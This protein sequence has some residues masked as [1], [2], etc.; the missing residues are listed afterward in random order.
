MREITTPQGTS[1][2]YDLRD[3][4]TPP[5]GVPAL[6]SGLLACASTYVIAG[7]GGIG[8]T[9]LAL[10]LAAHVASGQP[11]LGH[12][13]HSPA[14]V[15]FA[16][17]QNGEARLLRRIWALRRSLA[18]RPELPVYAMCDTRLIAYGDGAPESLAHLAAIIDGIGARLVVI[19]SL[20]DTL[21]KAEENNNEDMALVI[22][23]FRRVAQITGATIVAIHHVAK[24]GNDWRGASAIRDQ[25]DGLITVSRVEEQ[26]G[27]LRFKTT[28]SRDYA[29]VE[30]QIRASFGE[31]EIVIERDG[32]VAASS[33]RD[34]LRDAILSACD[35]WTGIA[36][37]ADDLATTER[38]RNRVRV[39]VYRMIQASLLDRR[40]LDGR[41]QV[42]RKA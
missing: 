29:E 22:D 18:L 4:E 9:W 19:D 17:L 39:V 3:V 36:Q 41:T 30:M 11:W 6:V 33:K 20:V 24:N 8:K 40:S 35:E 15:L 42:R 28:K 21:G 31:D 37:L 16:D 26:R 7:A 38:E 5:P 13:I 34:D 32:A 14:P 25:A 10:H 1:R 23:S 12:A 2:I 27:V